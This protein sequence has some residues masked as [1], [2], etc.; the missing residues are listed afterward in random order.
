MIS[1]SFARTNIC[2]VLSLWVFTINALL[3]SEFMHSA[4]CNRS[5]ETAIESG[6]PQEST[7]EK[8][9]SSKVVSDD[10][11]VTNAASDLV[12]ETKKPISDKI[13]TDKTTHT[14]NPWRD[15]L[16]PNFKNYAELPIE[17]NFYRSR[18]ILRHIIFVLGIVSAKLDDL[19]IDIEKEARDQLSQKLQSAGYAKHGSLVGHLKE[20]INAMIKM[21]VLMKQMV[22]DYGPIPKEE[23]ERIA[24]QREEAERKSEKE[25][26]KKAEKVQKTME[27]YKT[28]A[29]QHYWL[30]QVYTLSMHIYEFNMHCLAPATN[31][32]WLIV[33]FAKKKLNLKPDYA[34]QMSAGAVWALIAKDPGL[35]KSEDKATQLNSH[36]NSVTALV[37]LSRTEVHELVNYYLRLHPERKSDTSHVSDQGKILDVSEVPEFV[38]CEKYGKTYADYLMELSGLQLHLNAEGK[39]VIHFLKKTDED[40]TSEF[41]KKITGNRYID[42]FNTSSSIP[43]HW[44]TAYDQASNHWRMAKNALYKYE[45]PTEAGNP[46]RSCFDIF[47]DRL[48]GAIQY[49]VDYALEIF[50]HQYEQVK[51]HK[52]RSGE[53]LHHL[54][55]KAMSGLG[56]IIHSNKPD[57]G[58]KKQKAR[59][60]KI[61]TNMTGKSSKGQLSP[62][63]EKTAKQ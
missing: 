10:G 52:R 56:L 23:S 45:H 15:F 3:M 19:P 36:I 22:S 2:H 57:S 11:T 35:S 40:N 62:I 16:E 53:P 20:Q 14:S 21:N 7:P 1:Y 12:S 13:A 4:A 54:A 42:N 44:K 25:C 9:A 17:N 58:E 46:N 59:V 30:Q 48:R 8:V 50:D 26:S 37:L 27:V 61:V 47:V 31:K 5:A 29:S 28:Q 6:L 60:G 55:R 63:D 41:R 32:M 43:Y 38:T 51:I 49:G 34:T 33:D 39:K 24:K 18:S